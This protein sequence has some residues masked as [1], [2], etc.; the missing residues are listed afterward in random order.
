MSRHVHGQ[1]PW[2]LQR[3][4]GVYLAVY[5]V[6]VIAS[7]MQ[8]GA[9]SHQEWHAWLGH[10][11]MGIATAGFILAMLV[12]GWVGMRDVILDYVHPLGI[13][14]LLL[15]LIGLALITCGLWAL[16]VLVLAAG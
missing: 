4:S 14:L 2:L 15:V 5:L 16:R 7:S 12:H 9:Y 11:V 8:H 10:P 1:R 13:R 6:Y 3:L